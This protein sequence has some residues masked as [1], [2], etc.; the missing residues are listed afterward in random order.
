MEGSKELLVADDWIFPRGTIKDTY[1]AV[2][3]IPEG[4]VLVGH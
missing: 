1:T 3:D 2:S 4:C